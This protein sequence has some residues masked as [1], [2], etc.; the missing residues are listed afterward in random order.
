[1][2]TVIYAV[3]ANFCV[4]E[5]FLSVIFSPIKSLISLQ[6]TKLPAIIKDGKS[7]I[8]IL[9]FAQD[10]SGGKQKAP[11]LQWENFG[12]YNNYNLGK[13]YLRAL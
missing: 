9:S 4:R 5:L 13:L 3:T 8:K 6:Y 7:Q 10:D 11:K 12:L 2:H 1:M